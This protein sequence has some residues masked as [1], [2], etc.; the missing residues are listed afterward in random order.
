[1]IGERFRRATRQSPCVFQCLTNYLL[2]ATFI[3]L[4]LVPA[5][6]IDIANAL[7]IGLFVR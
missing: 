1:M 5:F 2:K 3:I 6:F 4:P 7:L